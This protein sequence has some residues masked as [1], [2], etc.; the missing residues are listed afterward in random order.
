MSQGLSRRALLGG[1]ALLLGGTGR[2]GLAEGPGQGRLLLVLLRGGLDGLA[3]LPPHG[4]PEYRL[5]RG[6]A[7][8]PGPG[9]RDGALDLDGTFSLH[10]SMSA[11]L[12]LWRAGALAPVVGL[13]PPGGSRSHFDAQ[14]ILD[15]GTDR[16][17]ATPDGWLNR[18]IAVRGGEALGLGLGLPRVLSGA[19]VVHSR[20]P[21]REPGLDADFLEEVAA[22][23]A[24]DPVLG[25]AL[26]GHRPAEGSM[27]GGRA[28]RSF[29][30]AAPALGALLAREAQVAA[31]ELE[32]WDT[33]SGQRARLEGRLSDLAQGLSALPEAMGAA[34][35][36]TA[37]VV[38][39][40][41]GRTVAGNGTGGTDHGSGGVGL[42]LGGAVAGGRV[43]GQWPGLA[44]LRDG[45]DLRPSTDSRSLFK[46]L[47]P[48]LLGVPEGLLEDRIFPG[49]RS[50]APLE[51]LCRA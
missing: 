38:V 36:R 6:S 2:M 24:R 13:A 4:E 31:I 20:D 42:L 49:S 46:G 23:Y 7:A 16:P 15:N 50:A 26:G 21:G 28:R 51:G 41:F 8:L 45:R 47:L 19:A 32:G 40:E 35:S 3:L 9:S 43:L 14:D 29:A 12:P 11:L 10:P 18:L 1:A 44:H 37:V 17:Y 33:H 22:L 48:A 39:S 34:W 5:A 25:P 27:E 30:R